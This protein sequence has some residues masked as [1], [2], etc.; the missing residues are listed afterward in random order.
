MVLFN[1]HTPFP[2]SSNLTVY[3]HWIGYPVEFEVRHAD[4]A[5]TMQQVTLTSCNFFSYLLTACSLGHEQSGKQPNTGPP[6]H[7][8]SAHCCRL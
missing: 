1:R 2:L 5:L 4:A 6:K 8:C 7:I 3:W